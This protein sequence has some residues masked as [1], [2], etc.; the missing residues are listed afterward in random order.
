M[1]FFLLAFSSLLFIFACGKDEVEQIK[2][3]IPEGV[4]VPEGMT[5]TKPALVKHPEEVVE[6]DP[7][8]VKTAT[9]KKTTKK[10]TAKKK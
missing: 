7:P 10:T 6:N 2:V 5:V 8:I 4:I 3:K 9:A 1:R